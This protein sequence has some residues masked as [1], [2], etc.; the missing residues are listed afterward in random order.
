MKESVPF[1]FFSL[2]ALLRGR[3]DTLLLGFLT[4]YSAVGYYQLAFRVMFASFFVPVVVGLMF[5]PQLST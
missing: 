2:L 4:D 5:F 3:L 1:A